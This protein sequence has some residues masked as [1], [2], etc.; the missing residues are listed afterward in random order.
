MFHFVANL[1][2]YTYHRGR[3]IRRFDSYLL[4]VDFVGAHAALGRKAVSGG[5]TLVADNGNFDR[6]RGLIGHYKAAASEIEDSRKGEEER[7]GRYARPGDLSPGLVERYRRFAQAVADEQ[8]H[9]TPEQ[10]LKA[11]VGEQFA[12]NPRYLVGMEDLTLPV[13]TALSVEPEYTQWPGEFYAGLVSR[14]LNYCVRTQRGELGECRGAVFAGLHAQDLD[15]ARLAGSLA[16]EAGVAGIASGLG[17]ALADRNYVDFRIAGGELIELPRT[18]PRPY[19]RV[20]EIAAGFHLGFADATGRRPRFHSLGVGTPILLVLLAALGDSQTLLA[21]DST[22]PIVDA[23]LTPTVSLYVDEPATLKLK[24]YRIAE[25][26]LSKG[27]SWDCPCPYCRRFNAEHPPDVDGARRW[28]RAQGQRRLKK[29]D[30][31]SKSELPRYLPLLGFHTNDELSQEAALARV[32]HNH[33]VLSRIERDARAASGDTDSLLGWT[34]GKV[35]AYLDSSAGSAWKAA[36]A[37]AWPVIRDAADRL[38][39]VQ[40]TPPGW[41]RERG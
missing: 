14:A 1:K 3:G 13:L 33:W 27:L 21:S 18:I 6:I 16:G 22:A 35:Q 10:Q 9:A 26:W 17:G 32:G 38:R 23:W 30:M 41:T 15:T 20:A 31:H 4:S 8:L 5:H 7:L 37:V 11:V 24:A 39:D 2:D 28:W 34:E 29:Y 12:L 25:Y 19:L 36:V 40:P